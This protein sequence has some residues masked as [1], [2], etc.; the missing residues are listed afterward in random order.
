MMLS[1]WFH[2]TATSRVQLEAAGQTATTRA[3]EK[4][5]WRTVKFRWALVHKW[6][7]RQPEWNKAGFL[8]PQKGNGPGVAPNQSSQ[9]AAPSSLRPLYLWVV[10]EKRKRKIADTSSSRWSSSAGAESSS[11]NW[12]DRC[13]ELLCLWPDRS[14]S[15][16]GSS[17][18]TEPTQSTPER[19]P[20]LNC[21]RK[22]GEIIS[23]HLCQNLYHQPCV[24][25][26]KESRW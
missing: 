6:L 14:S 12:E 25:K 18:T 13:I 22:G 9:F 19:G 4:K 20:I 23:K 26:R 3:G 5:K 10:T 11:A 16:G 17:Q 1:A 24:W 2:Q 8:L 15:W 7:C 21:K